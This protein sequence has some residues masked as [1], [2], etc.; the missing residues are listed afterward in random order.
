MSPTSPTPIDVAGAARAVRRLVEPYGATYDGAIDLAALRAGHRPAY[1][2]A[3]T[4]SVDGN[5]AAA[6][7]F[8]QFWRSPIVAGFPITPATKWLEHLAAESAK[9]KFT[10]EVN[11]RAARTRRLLRDE[12]HPPPRPPRGGAR[13]T[14][15]PFLGRDAGAG[16]GRRPGGQL[17]RRGAARPR[18]ATRPPRRRHRDGELRD[19]RV[20]PGIQGGPE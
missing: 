11:G 2:E 12:G 15:E 9:A 16:G 1:R 8:L 20:L 7:P 19:Q 5:T 18:H 6:I 13:R 17:Q 4:L 14:G 10:V 3:T